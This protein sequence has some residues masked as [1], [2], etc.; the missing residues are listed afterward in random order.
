M[1]DLVAAAFGARPVLTPPADALSETVE[2]IAASLSANPGLLAEA[3]GVPIGSVLL[4]PDRSTLWLRR[5]AVR[6]DHQRHGIAHALVAA[7]V[8]ASGS[9]YCELAVVA[10]EEL[11]STVRFWRSQDF[12]TSSHQ[13]PLIEMRRPV[14]PIDGF[15][16]V[17]GTA[18]AMHE[19]GVGLGKRLRAGDLVVLVG[20]LGAGKTTLTR[21]IGEG[22]GIRGPVTSPT[23]IIARE[24]PSVVGG[25]G[26]V[27]V[28]AYRLGG[29]GELDDLDLDT[30]L[31]HAVTVVEWGRNM[32]EGLAQS[33]LEIVIDRSDA[34]VGE[35]PDAEPR[36][37]RI[38]AVGP[39][40]T[41][42]TW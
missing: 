28:D 13:P 21:G 7:A 25:P 23:F 35:D 17:V 12:I 30:D 41:G 2:T 39:R 19:L 8:E 34:P 11:P 42:V 5:F 6:P 4:D 32:A 24:H 38:D 20:D 26:L 15:D 14:G 1:L 36:R 29:T 37:V 31:D 18:T 22:M 10:R 40:W 9:G 33:R 3:D 16:R 27:H